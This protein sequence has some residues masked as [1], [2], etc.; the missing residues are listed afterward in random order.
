MR[1]LVIKRRKAAPNGRKNMAVYICDPA[2]EKEIHGNLCRLLGTVGNGDIAAFPVE[3]A[4]VKV[5]VVPED[6]EKDALC[7]Y[8]TL[9]AGNA[10]VF[11]TGCCQFSPFAGHP[12]HFDGNDRSVAKRQRRKL[13][14][15]TVC[16]MVAAA[17]IG[18]TAANVVGAY[19]IRQRNNTPQ[20]FRESGME[21]TLTQDF[22][23]IDVSDQGFYTGFNSSNT[24]IYV[25]RETFADDPSLGYLSLEE[26]A[27]LVLNSSEKE[28]GGKPT[29]QDGLTYYEYTA[30]SPVNGKRYNYFVCFY[31]GPDGFWMIEFTTLEDNAAE[32]RP[33]YIQYAKSVCFPDNAI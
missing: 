21:I 1:N 20:L 26:Y 5:Y 30:R 11:L 14:L 2:G 17:A 25:Q 19:R 9:P 16:C 18:I 6:M 12:F 33:A 29:Q 28:S 13:L 4:E 15:I 10:D 31:K 23:Q 27:Q 32:M 7:E 22:Q 3:E 24:T 8:C